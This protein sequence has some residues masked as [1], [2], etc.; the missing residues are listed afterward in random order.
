LLRVCL[1]IVG[2]IRKYHREHDYVLCPHTA[3]G[4]AAAED[5]IARHGNKG[6]DDS[7]PVVCLATAHPAKFN[8]AVREVYTLALLAPTKGKSR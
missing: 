2:A 3:C 8:D 6:K 7:V 1:Q 4:V 5:Y